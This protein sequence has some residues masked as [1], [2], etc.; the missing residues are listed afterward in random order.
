MFYAVKERIG[1]LCLPVKKTKLIDDNQ[2]Q[3]I[4]YISLLIN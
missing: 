4:K 3:G 1:V 2:L